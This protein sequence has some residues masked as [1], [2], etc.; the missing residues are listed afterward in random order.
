M[1]EI[2]LYQTVDLCRFLLFSAAKL[3]AYRGT[4]LIRR[5]PCTSLQMH[6]P[7][8]RHCLSRNSSPISPR[9]PWLRVEGVGCRVHGVGLRV[10]WSMV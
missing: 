4:L 6:R 7:H 1:S 2:P 5:Y 8:A 9:P 3:S 10:L